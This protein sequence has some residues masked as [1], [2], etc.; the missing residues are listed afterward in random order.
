M[1]MKQGLVLYE[2]YLCVCRH[3]RDWKPHDG[4]PLSSIFFLDSCLHAQEEYVADFQSSLP[5]FVFILT[6]VFPH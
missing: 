3:V 5:V 1:Q 4:R 6:A 2:M